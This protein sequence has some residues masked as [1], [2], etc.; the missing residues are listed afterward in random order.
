MKRLTMMIAAALVLGACDGGETIGTGGNGDSS[1]TTSVG[2]GGQGGNGGGGGC[3][4]PSGDPHDFTCPQPAGGGGTGGN[5]GAGGEAPPVYTVDPPWEV[6]VDGIIDALNEGN[7][8]APFS[9]ISNEDGSWTRVVATTPGK[10]IHKLRFVAARG[11]G[12]GIPDSWNISVSNL[13]VSLDPAFADCGVGATAQEVEEIGSVLMSGPGDEILE[14]VVL[15]VTYG[16]VSS[17][18][19]GSHDII[20]IQNYTDI[21]DGTTTAI[22]GCGAPDAGSDARDQ[23]QDNEA[24]GGGIH[25]MCSYGSNYCVAWMVT[26]L[27]E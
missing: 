5:G 17:S 6:S 7:A 16:N 10:V 20:C 22:V 18:S 9:R 13:A 14:F 2:G 8:C 1:T 27:A 24:L 4:G 21:G 3:I 15:E 25:G 26:T 11:A 19:D 23:W 12:Y